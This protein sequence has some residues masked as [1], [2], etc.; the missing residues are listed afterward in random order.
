[1]EDYHR[2]VL[3]ETPEESAYQAVP[4]EKTEKR[5]GKRIVERQGKR[6]VVNGGS[7]N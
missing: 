4:L 6:I 2:H 1:V 3:Q 7:A 5:Q